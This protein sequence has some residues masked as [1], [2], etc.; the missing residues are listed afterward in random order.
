MT[1]DHLVRQFLE[2]IE[3]EK[4]RSQKTIE[5]YQHY[6]NRFLDFA[7]SNG[8]DSPSAI[9]LDMIHQYRLFLNRFHHY[10]D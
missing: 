10:H 8:V 2:H 5:N 1:L 6:L 3:V 7:E 4:G 9:N